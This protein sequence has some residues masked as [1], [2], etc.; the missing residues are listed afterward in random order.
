M[1]LAERHVQRLEQVASLKLR[2][3][4]LEEGASC[5]QSFL[6]CADD[7]DDQTEK[8]TENQKRKG[9]KSTK[10]NQPFSYLLCYSASIVEEFDMSPTRQAARDST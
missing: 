10:G 9:T 2:D 5:G 7:S 6:G 8:R 4:Q 1:T 3:E